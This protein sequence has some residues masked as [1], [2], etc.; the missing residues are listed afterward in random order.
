MICCIRKSWLPSYSSHSSSSSSSPLLL[1]H[2]SWRFLFSAL[3]RVF[4]VCDRLWKHSSEHA[5]RENLLHPLC[6]IW[7]PS[8]WLLVGGDRWPAG[9]HLRE[10]HLEGWEDIQGELQIKATFSFIHICHF[11][12][13]MFPFSLNCCCI[14]LISPVY[15]SKNTNRSARLRSEWR[16]P[17]CSSWPAAL[18]LSPSLLSSSNTSRAGPLWRPSTLW[19]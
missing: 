3:P 13:G 1:C 11:L 8:L 10:K 17:S 9:H 6:H 7:H 18:F 14:V 19:W 16:P 2:V 15:L 12:N 4:L 5:G